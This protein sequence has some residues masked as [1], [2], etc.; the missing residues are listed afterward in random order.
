MVEPDTSLTP[1]PDASASGPSSLSTIAP[2]PAQNGAVSAPSQAAEG[3]SSAE[4]LAPLAAYDPLD[5]QQRVVVERRGAME[6]E[7]AQPAEPVVDE[8][9]RPEAASA[10]E[11]T[12][13]PVPVDELLSASEL[14]AATVVKKDED[15]TPRFVVL[16]EIIYGLDP[17]ARLR[18]GTG[19]QW[20]KLVLGDVI[21]TPDDLL[22]RWLDPLQRQELLGTLDEQAIPLEQLAVALHLQEADPYDV[23]RKALFDLPPLTRAERAAR[24]RW[25]QAAFFERFAANALAASVLDAILDWYITVP[26]TALSAASELNVSSTGLLNLPALKRLGTPMEIAGAFR[27]CGTYIETALEELQQLL[28]SV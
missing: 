4:P 18:K 26:M 12:D 27:S 16:G 19:Q 5:E 22:A 23:L 3:T 25:E 13:L 15:G 6:G 24:L 2:T 11:Q 17:E 9:A 1:E 14:E 7:V 8:P 10:Q 21:R 28:Y 20:A